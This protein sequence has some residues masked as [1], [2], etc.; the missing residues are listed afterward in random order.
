M[1]FIFSPLLLLNS[2]ESTPSNIRDENTV[3]NQAE[4]AE[5]NP[6]ENAEDNKTEKAENAK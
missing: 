5:D 3:I 1:C 6:V 4:N 2:A